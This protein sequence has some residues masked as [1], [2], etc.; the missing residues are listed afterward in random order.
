MFLIYDILF[1]IFSIFY[2]PYLLLKRKWH[3]KMAMR[4]GFF[5][6]EDLGLSD[7][8]RIWIHAVSV[9]EVMVIRN[10]IKKIKAAYPQFQIVVS[11]VT[12]TGFSLAKTIVDSEDTL[13][14]APVDLS[15]AVRK[16][17]RLIDPILYLNAE[18]ELW[19]NFLTALHAR[20]IPIIQINGRISDS[21]FKGYRFTKFLFKRIL[22]FVTVF[23]MQ[24]EL[25]AKRI[26]IMGADEGKIYPVGNMKFDDAAPIHIQGLPRVLMNSNDMVFIAGSTHPGE[27]EIILNIIH[28]IDRQFPNLRLILA[29]RH[30]ERAQEV[31][32]LCTQKGFMAIK[33]SELKERLNEEVVVVDTI[34]HLRSLFS[35]ADVVFVGKSLTVKG[36]HNIVEPA[37]FG[38]AIITG[39]FMQNFRDITKIFLENEAV[40]QV[41]DKNELQTAVLRLLQ[42]KALRVNLG[43]NARNTIEK[44]RGATEK[45]FEIISCIL[46]D[47]A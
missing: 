9:G 2:L 34:G 26:Q 1:I 14:Y 12:P 31:M 10:L 32:R 30:P 21:A 7:K 43:N 39:P 18:T 16:Y 6:K 24:S 17:V 46:G 11:V 33:F 28:E 15:F 25:D 41:K 47:K 20:D 4:F 3:N 40:V 19:P 8:K 44:Y 23:C 27:E 37:C 5:K 42:N 38:K 13:I 29:P 35:L 45:T 36:G 22:S